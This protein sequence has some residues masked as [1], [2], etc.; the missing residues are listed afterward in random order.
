MTRCGS[1][2]VVLAVAAG[3]VTWGGAAR[4][5]ADLSATVY[6]APAFISVGQHASVFVDIMNVGTP[7]GAQ[8]VTPS[9]SLTTS[10]AGVT[11]RLALSDPSLVTWISG[12]T[13]SCTAYLTPNQHA[14]FT[15]VYQGTA[16]GYEAF[17]VSVTG[18]EDSGLAT[19][20]AAQ[21]SAALQVAFAANLSATLSTEPPILGTYRQSVTVFLEVGN[22]GQGVAD[23]V[24]AVSP[25]LSGTASLAYRGCPYLG[26]LG[27]DCPSTLTNIAPGSSAIFTWLYTDVTPGTVTLTGSAVGYDHS[28]GA[29]VPSN[30]T[31]TVLVVP[32][33]AVLSLTVT[34]LAD[35]V[36][37][38]TF[39]LKV[40]ITNTGGTAVCQSG[41]DVTL[42]GSAAAL[43]SVVPELHD[44]HDNLPAICF[45]P[46]QTRE[47]TLLVQ[48]RDDTPLG[49]TPLAVVSRAQEEWTGT[50]AISEGAPLA[51]TLF[52][53]RPGITGI[54][55]NPFRLSVSPSTKITYVVAPSQSGLPVS[56][57]VYSLSGELI[58]TLADD[59]LPAGV[60][61]A[62]WDGRNHDRQRVAGGIVLVLYEGLG[63]KD[64]RKL[65]VIK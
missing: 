60:Y 35:L 45:E 31:K 21:T 50:P 43:Q 20:L 2:A 59:A 55:P 8:F 28:T 6:A 48:L 39:R 29:T 58:R 1:G 38:Q 47:F 14:Y 34:G 11:N 17:T 40:M 12:P 56:I 22:I 44:L 13:P 19:L 64:V 65:A 15:W 49:P 9:D 32:V 18:Q 26:A 37:G 10:C 4:A 53:Q 5:A 27:P 16:T 25:V 30:T 23:N 52:A 41:L 3:L 42:G 63:K 33:P 24:G 51:V 54:S 7:E 62:A 46:G 61:D 57:K 36:Q